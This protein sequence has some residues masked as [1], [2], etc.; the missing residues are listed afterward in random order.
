MNPLGLTVLLRPSNS[1]HDCREPK[2]YP[3]P[4][5]SNY[6]LGR[7]AYRFINTVE[8]ILFKPQD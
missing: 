4:I 3:Q 2:N 6:F 5:E 7:A 8:W 1:Q